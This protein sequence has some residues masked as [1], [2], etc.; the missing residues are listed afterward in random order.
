MAYSCCP[1][2]LTPKHPSKAY[3]KFYVESNLP[4]SFPRVQYQVLICIYFISFIPEGGDFSTT[5]GTLSLLRPLRDCEELRRAASQSNLSA[6][7]FILP[8]WRSCCLLAVTAL[9]VSRPAR[10]HTGH[11]QPAAL[12]PLGRGLSMGMRGRREAEVNCRPS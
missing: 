6:A 8:L 5:A 10:N 3:C 7:L 9:F 12:W 4:S 11:L 1:M 2:L